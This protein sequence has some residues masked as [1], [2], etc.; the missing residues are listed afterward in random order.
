MSSWNG[1]KLGTKTAAELGILLRAGT[2]NPILP[3]TRD[4]LMTI[5][6]RNGVLY[7]EPDMAARRFSLPCVFIGASTA[8]ELETAA[9]A[10][11]THLTDSG[12]PKKLALIFEWDKDVYYDVYYSGRADLARGVF[13][14]EF[15]LQ[16]IAPDPDAKDVE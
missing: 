10:L 4:R 12:K 7:F 16:L 6:G 5:P 3:T 1:F 14:G 15:E 9:K 2:A 11:A 13:D 8:E